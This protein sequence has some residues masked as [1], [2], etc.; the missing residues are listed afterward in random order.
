YIKVSERVGPDTV[1]PAEVIRRSLRAVKRVHGLPRGSGVG[2]AANNPSTD[3]KPFDNDVSLTCD[4]NPRC[5]MNEDRRRADDPAVGRQAIDG[6]EASTGGAL[7]DYPSAGR[8][9]CV[10][11][12]GDVR[13]AR[14][15]RRDGVGLI[16]PTA[17]EWPNIVNHL[18]ARP[19]VRAPS[20][21][22]MIGPV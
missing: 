12:T 19:A 7:A 3:S 22:P 18:P 20:H 21:K 16:K 8:G 2:A 9:S 13:I 14:R 15:V 6:A 1:C 5:R 10:H 4:E 11:P 17:A